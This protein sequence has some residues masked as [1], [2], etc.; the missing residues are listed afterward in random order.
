MGKSLADERV[1]LTEMVE[2]A[3]FYIMLLRGP[4]FLIEGFNR[5]LELNVCLARL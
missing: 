4:G 1:R 2:L 5:D 3:P